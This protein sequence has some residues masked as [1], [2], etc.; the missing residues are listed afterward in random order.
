MDHTVIAQVAPAGTQLYQS[1]SSSM[2]WMIRIAIIFFLIITTLISFLK[3]SFPKIF[4]YLLFG[5][6]FFIFSFFGADFMYTIFKM[7]VPG[8]GPAPAPAS[9]KP[10]V[11]QPAAPR[12]ASPSSPP[13]EIPWGTIF[14][15]VG[16]IVALIIAIV[17]IL[18]IIDAVR[19]HRSA[20]AEKKVLQE[21]WTTISN[22]VADIEVKA[23][24]LRLYQ[25]RGGPSHL[26]EEISNILSKA[27]RITLGN[28]KLLHGEYT[29]QELNAFEEQA[30]PAELL[31]SIDAV[32]KAYRETPPAESPS[33][34][35]K[36]VLGVF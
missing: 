13:A 36:K 18:C 27:D 26:M 30:R 21:R 31:S 3:G 17:V 25:G 12:P 14:T 6:V 28:E 20:A 8:S 35:W 32:D 29:Q 15:V 2:I 24:F 5:L 10:A 11:P 34:Q 19:K 4:P 16:L 33:P 9:P 23:D 7:D 22:M 1:S